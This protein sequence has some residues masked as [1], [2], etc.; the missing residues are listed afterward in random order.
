MDTGSSSIAVQAFS[1]RVQ[2]SSMDAIHPF[3]Y[4]DED[5]YG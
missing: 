2:F 4:T 3:G 1:E 5:F